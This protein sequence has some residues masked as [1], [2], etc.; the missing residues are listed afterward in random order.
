MVFTERAVGE[1]MRQGFAVSKEFWLRAYQAYHAMP[2]AASVSLGCLGVLNSA[3]HERESHSFVHSLVRPPGD[4]FIIRYA[5]VPHRDLI[6][7]LLLLRINLY[8]EK[9]KFDG[10]SMIAFL[11]WICS[12]QV[13]G[14]PIST[15]SATSSSK[16]YV[17]CASIDTYTVEWFL[18]E[19]S[20]RHIF[21]LD[22]ALFYTRG[23]SKMAK[24]YACDHDLITIW[25][26]WDQSLY[27]YHD[28]STNA[29]RCIHNNEAER[30]RFFAS[31]SEAYARL[32]TGTVIVMHDASDW[33]HPPQDGIW[34]QVEYQTM[35]HVTQTVT[36]ILKLKEKDDASALV[37][38]D[39]E[40]PLSSVFEK[41]I[42]VVLA[43]GRYVPSFLGD[44]ADWIAGSVES[45]K[46]TILDREQHTKARL[47]KACRVPSY[48]NPRLPFYWNTENIILNYG[49]T[50]QTAADQVMTGGDQASLLLL[51]ELCEESHEL[52]QFK[53]ESLAEDMD[54]DMKELFSMSFVGGA[55]EDMENAPDLS[56]DVDI[57]KISEQESDSDMEVMANT[58]PTKAAPPV[59]SSFAPVRRHSPPRFSVVHGVLRCLRPL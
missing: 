8:A 4:P 21:D 28:E 33:T 10:Y 1:F 3:R 5:S 38:W 32:A 40:Q 11:I 47:G 35:V 26:V 56:D 59:D 54:K 49:A 31:M 20:K 13:L 50:V 37:I 57:D 39:R 34:H 22:N 17:Q 14:Y 48:P 15:R 24:E 52:L 6:H 41:P 16:D 45:A 2:L 7:T 29:M 55:D 23:M 44:A 51:E 12:I 27:D 46:Q 25:S 9:S 43:T 36:T 42:S 30:Q 58:K 18:A 53:N 19:A